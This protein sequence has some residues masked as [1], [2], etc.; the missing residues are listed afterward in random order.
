MLVSLSVKGMELVSGWKPPFPDHV[1][2]LATLGE[3]VR[4]HR[5]FVFPTH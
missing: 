4:G 5:Q 3:D 2:G 1:R